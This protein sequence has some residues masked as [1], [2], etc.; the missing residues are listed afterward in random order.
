[1]RLTEKE[2]ETLQAILDSEYGMGCDCGERNIDVPVWS[3]S[4][5]VDDTWKAGVFSSL[6]KKCLVR[7]DGRGKD[8]CVSI[9]ADGYAALVEYRQSRL[10]N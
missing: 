5:Y 9:T 6:V 2:A 8:A 7:Q 3:F 10:T 1:M 4:V